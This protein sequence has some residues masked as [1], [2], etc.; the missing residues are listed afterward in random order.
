MAS[1]R[2]LVTRRWLVRDDAARRNSQDSGSARRAEQ[3]R[4]SVAAIPVDGQPNVHGSKPTQRLL[5]RLGGLGSRSR[6]SRCNLALTAPRLIPKISAIVAKLSPRARKL[7]TGT[8]TGGENCVLSMESA[9]EDPQA[10]HAGESTAGFGLSASRCNL[11]Q[12]AQHGSPDVVLNTV[13]RRIA[14]DPS[15]GE[16]ARS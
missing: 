12:L 9:V 3:F 16:S 5:R 1:L 15:G 14:E 8:A 6:R 13:K 10:K 4:Q 7:D 2:Q 11:A